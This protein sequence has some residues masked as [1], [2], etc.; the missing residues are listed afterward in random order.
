MQRKEIKERFFFFWFVNS[1]NLNVSGVEKLKNLLTNTEWINVA[2]C[3]IPVKES[4]WTL[5]G[6]RGK[7]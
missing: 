4:V 7:E 6:Y 2:I 3:Y 1:M 5:G